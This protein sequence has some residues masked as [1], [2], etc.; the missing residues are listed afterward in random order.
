MKKIDKLMSKIVDFN[1]KLIEKKYGKGRPAQG[2]G[3]L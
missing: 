1:S 3:F 2:P